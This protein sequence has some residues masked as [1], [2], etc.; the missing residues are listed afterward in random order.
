MV[1][2]NVG[3]YRFHTRLSTLCKFEDCMLATMFNGNH[4]LDRDEDG[5]YFIDSSGEHFGAI[6]DFLRHGR[7]PPNEITEAVYKEAC[8]Y[9]I[10]PLIEQLQLRPAIAK[11]VVLESHRAQ[12][13]NYYE[14]KDTIIR[15]AIE[16]AVISKIGEVRVHAYQKEFVP[17]TPNFK[18]DHDCTADTAHVTIGPW[19]AQADEEI[20]IRCIEHDLVEDGFS[21]KPHEQKKRCKY[22]NGQNCQKAIYKITILFKSC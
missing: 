2:L 17:R 20:F 15:I 12:F 5:F 6:I 13:P 7:L 18:T 10:V 8:Y 22:N 21:I 11:T 14:V 1:P 19:S 16:K 9:H 4:K 3:G